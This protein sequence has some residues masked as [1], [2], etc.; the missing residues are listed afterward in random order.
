MESASKVSASTVAVDGS[1]SG[2]SWSTSIVSTSSDSLI[3]GPSSA[4][5]GDTPTATSPMQAIA[6]RRMATERRFIEPQHPT[7]GSLDRIR[8][9]QSDR[10]DRRRPAAER[11]VVRV[12]VRFVTSRVGF[13]V[14]VHLDRLRLEVVGRIGAVGFGRRVV[15][16]HQDGFL[17]WADVLDVVGRRE[18]A[19]L[20][21]GDRRF[22]QGLAAS[23]VRSFD[24]RVV[25]R[26]SSRSPSS[27]TTTRTLPFLYVM[28]FAC[29]YTS[30]SDASVRSCNTG[31]S[32]FVSFMGEES[33]VDSSATAT[34][35]MATVVTV[36]VITEKMRIF[37]TRLSAI[38]TSSDVEDKYVLTERSLEVRCSRRLERVWTDDSAGIRWARTKCESYRWPV[39]N[40]EVETRRRRSE[41]CG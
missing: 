9:H 25:S 39:K 12:G 18:V 7:T 19:E 35:V 32:D 3:D 5:A 14:R 36:A 37:Q 20:I 6:I 40:K 4:A 2:S 8:Q 16:G 30:G 13:G 11:I 22:D 17:G 27:S 29:A 33:W 15:V 28:S 34:G 24:R 26:G 31:A 21:D 10:R 38:P 41:S 1:A 23:A